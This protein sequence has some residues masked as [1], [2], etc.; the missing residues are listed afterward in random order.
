MVFSMKDD[1]IEE[2]VRQ[3]MGY[4]Y[5]MFNDLQQVLEREGVQARMPMTIIIQ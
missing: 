3:K 5:P 4:F 2:A 1:A